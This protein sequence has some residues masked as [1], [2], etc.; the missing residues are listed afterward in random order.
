MQFRS[1]PALSALLLALALL[2]QRPTA[3]DTAP[4]GISFMRTINTEAKVRFEQEVS[5]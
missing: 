4:K 5:T 3:A 2:G 1:S